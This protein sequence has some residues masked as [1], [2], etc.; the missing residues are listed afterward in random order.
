M[1]NNLKR[2][3]LALAMVPTTA[4]AGLALVGNENSGTIS[5]IVPRHCLLKLSICTSIG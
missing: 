2:L 3:L 5:L 4:L 1:T